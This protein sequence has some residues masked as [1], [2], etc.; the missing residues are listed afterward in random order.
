LDNVQ[1]GALFAAFAGVLAFLARFRVV[2]ASVAL[3]ATASGKQRAK[4]I[5]LDFPAIFFHFF[6][7]ANQLASALLARA[8]AAATVALVG[9]SATGRSAAGFLGCCLRREQGKRE[10]QKYSDHSHVYFLLPLFRR[11]MA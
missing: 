11:V 3:I 7:A 10:R 6:D 1:A 4:F 5:A 8:F 2:L 9:R